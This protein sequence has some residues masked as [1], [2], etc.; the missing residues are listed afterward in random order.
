[1]PA[2]DAAPIITTPVGTFDLH[3]GLPADQVERFLSDDFVPVSHETGLRPGKYAIGHETDGD[4]GR[5]SWEQWGEQPWDFAGHADREDTT[6]SDPDWEK[7]FHVVIRCENI[8][9]AIENFGWLW[10][11]GFTFI[12]ARFP[13]SHGTIGVVSQAE[14][15][16]EQYVAFNVKQQWQ[17]RPSLLDFPEGS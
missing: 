17:F 10:H 2:F 9:S 1:M 16:A 3:V 6:S 11:E 14:D 5:T 7:G 15:W 4:T 12:P 8:G 13:G